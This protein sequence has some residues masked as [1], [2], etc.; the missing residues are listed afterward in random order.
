MNMRRIIIAGGVLAALF[1]LMIV[2]LQ[3][4]DADPSVSRP[5]PQGMSSTKPVQQKRAAVT[6][7]A[8]NNTSSAIP[9]RKDLDG[10][11]ALVAPQFSELST[12][13]RP[14]LA[15]RLGAPNTLPESE[16]KIVLDIL[17]AYRRYF[18]AFPAGE[19]NRQF[20][21]ALLGANKEK[22]PFI[23]HDHPR[24]NAN[25]ELLDAWGTPFYFHQN[26]RDSVQVRSAGADRIMYTEDDIVAGKAPPQMPGL[27]QKET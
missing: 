1:T 8:A 4:R 17:T 10:Q 26:S 23:P 27:P 2:L 18:R 11:P 24:I 21:N 14:P 12:T 20:V 6:A 5:S 22:L 19:N 13:E 9:V 16:P 3:Q 25:G 7:D 15:D